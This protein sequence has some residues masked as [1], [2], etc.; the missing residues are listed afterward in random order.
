M[1]DIYSAEEPA[2]L[3]QPLW[4]TFGSFWPKK[5]TKQKK[6]PALSTSSC[7]GGEAMS[8][9]TE[10]TAAPLTPLTVIIVF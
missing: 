7:V 9:L 2:R 8:G 6:S 1:S 3:A 10:A 5:A 4:F